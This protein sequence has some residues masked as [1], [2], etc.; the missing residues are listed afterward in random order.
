M[1]IVS[2]TILSVYIGS[3]LISTGYN[4][5]KNIQ[6]FFTKKDYSDY[7]H[8]EIILSECPLLFKSLIKK[9]K[10]INTIKSHRTYVMDGIIYYF[11]NIEFNMNDIIIK[12]NGIGQ[13]QSISLYSLNMNKL[14][15]FIVELTNNS[16]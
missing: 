6:N 15:D 14:K 10:I 16:Q 3:L 12:L 1:V 8:H 11:P 7:Y 2:G 4:A 13:T 5:Y 9:Y